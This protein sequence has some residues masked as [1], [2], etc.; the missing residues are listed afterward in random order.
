LKIRN[1]S[2][3]ELPD[4]FRHLPLRRPGQRARRLDA[5]R[6]PALTLQKL[7]MTLTRTARDLGSLGRDDLFG[8][9]VNAVVELTKPVAVSAESKHANKAPTKTGENTSE[10]KELPAPDPRSCD[11]GL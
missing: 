7:R 3:S 9:A 6:N 11:D 10:P 2:G 4:H 1:P 5:G 8:A